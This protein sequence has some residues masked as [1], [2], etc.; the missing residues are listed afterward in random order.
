ML[1]MEISHSGNN[2]NAV[3]VT[4]VKQV[5]AWLYCV[6]DSVSEA[7]VSSPSCPFKRRC[8]VVSW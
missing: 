3:I 6:Y 4:A 2:L 1:W 7:V 8:S 5:A